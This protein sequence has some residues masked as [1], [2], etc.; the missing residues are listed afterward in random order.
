MSKTLSIVVPYWENRIEKRDMLKRSTGSFNDYDEL[1]IMWND[2]LGFSKAVNRGFEIAKGDF[3]IMAS[4]DA[5]LAE[6][7]LR[8]LCVPGMV[9]SPMVNGRDQ[10]FSGVM[11][12]VPRGI[13]ETYGLLDENYTKGIYFEDEDY[14]M[15]L[16]RENIPHKCVTSVKVDHPEGGATLTRTP[17]FTKRTD[18]NREYFENKWGIVWPR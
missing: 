14:W 11:W 12:C 15:M 5:Y 2:G 9:T 13:Y 8:D 1:I 16:K 4:D 6:G 17:E 3:I 18:I 7:S 10:A